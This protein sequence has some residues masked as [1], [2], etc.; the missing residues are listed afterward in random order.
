MDETLL[1]EIERFL[2]LTGMKPTRFS[3]EAIGDR[4]F[5]RQL[6]LGRRVWPETAAKAR[7]FMAAYARVEQAA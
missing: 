4:H 1:P 2:T 7:S 5:V 3:Q 6:R